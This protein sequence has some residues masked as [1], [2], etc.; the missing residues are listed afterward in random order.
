MIT[1]TIV[2]VS[3][4]ALWGTAELVAFVLFNLNEVEY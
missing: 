4:L 1:P 2:F 3:I